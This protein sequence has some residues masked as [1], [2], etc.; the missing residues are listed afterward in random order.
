MDLDDIATSTAK[1]PAVEKKV[2]DI[3]E[4][5]ENPDIIENV[6]NPY[7]EGVY[8]TKKDENEYDGVD[9]TQEFIYLFT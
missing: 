9:D 8:D 7:Y 2:F 6:E 5:T 1:E 4:A 3:N